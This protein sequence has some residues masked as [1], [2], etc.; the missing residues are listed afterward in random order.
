M[1]PGDTRPVDGVVDLL[2]IQATPFCNLDCDYCYLPGRQSKE[3]ITPAVLRKIFERAFAS[4]LVGNEFTVVWHAGEP[5]A[6]PLAFYKEALTVVAEENRRGISVRHSFQT[7]ATLLTDEWCDFLLENNLAIGVSV[8]G[9]AFLHDRHRKTRGGKGTW[10]RVIGGM[11]RLTEHG[12]PFHVITVLT[13]ESLDFPDELFD[14]YRE[15]GVRTICFN[16]EEIEGPHTSSTLSPGAAQERYAQFLDRFFDLVQ[17]SGEKYAVREFDSAMAA[18]LPTQPAMK[19]RGPQQTTPF[20]IISVDCRGNFS[21][22]SPEL[23]GLPSDKYGDFS[24]GNVMT[25]SFESAL[26][27]PKFQAVAR[28]VA[29]G[30]QRCERTCEYFA[31]CGGGAPVNKL[32]E[33]GA[34]DSTETLFCRLT[35]KVPIDIV[36]RK[37]TEHH[38]A[39]RA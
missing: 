12:V 7:N 15:F 37:A 28:D 25:D 32:F 1:N 38:G 19:Y 4:P 35:R 29:A 39:V 5:L 6:M 10:E 33:N 21:T 24:F 27:S 16:I 36:L 17:Q 26:E 13:A 22:F 3:R 30:V 23:L 14:F 20:G 8:D 11:N 18:V 2:I 34:F 9:P 31:F